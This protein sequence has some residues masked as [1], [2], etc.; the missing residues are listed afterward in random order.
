MDTR[1]FTRCAKS[2]SDSFVCKPRFPLYTSNSE[3]L[4]CE[5]ELLDHS[6]EITKSCT[7]TLSNKNRFWIPITNNRFIFVLEKNSTVDQ[8]CGS[9]ISPFKISGS[10]IIEMS[11][12]CF[13]RDDDT[14]ITPEE[15]QGTTFNASYLPALNISFFPLNQSNLT[16]ITNFSNPIRPSD[17]TSND[18]LFHLIEQQ[19]QAEDNLPSSL[20]QHDIHHYVSNSLLFVCLAIFF[21]VFVVH[22]RGYSV[23]KWCRKSNNAPITPEETIYSIPNSTRTINDIEPAP[24]Q[25]II[26]KSG[27]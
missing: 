2:N 21:G 27:N 26:S 7:F 6:D 1:D 13:F 18:Y 24:R 19:K 14:I 9:S 17:S 10:G 11:K 20:N 16:K 12:G 5:L 8:I 23:T 15:L 4:R 25:K 22:Y 3:N